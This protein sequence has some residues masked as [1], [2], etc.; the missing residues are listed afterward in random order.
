[1]NLT[2]SPFGPGVDGNTPADFVA[3]WR[4]V[5]NRFAADG[6]TNVKWV[7]SPNVDCGGTCPFDA[8]YPGNS[9]VDYVALDGY[10]YSS[11]DSQPWMSFR[12][13]FT[14]SYADIT[15]LST[16]PV[17]IGETA[18][19]DAGGN[20]ATWIKTAFT[21]TI[22]VTFPRVVAVVWF[23]RVKETDWRV[24]SSPASLAAWRHVVASPTYQVSL[25][26]AVAAQ[27]GGSTVSRPAVGARASALRIGP[28]GSGSST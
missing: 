14:S 19:A 24:N 17:I 18:S 28:R 21:T 5:V 20:K 6:V 1:M 26:A 23:D 15:A 10:N 27:A 25:S 12:A 2:G 16:K 7:W 11:V 3:A 4:Y 9:Y 22:P 8:F 13:V